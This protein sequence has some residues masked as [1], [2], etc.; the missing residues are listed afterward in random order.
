MAQDQ[1]SSRRSIG[2]DPLTHVVERQRQENDGL[3]AAMRYRAVIEQAKGILM[4][5]TGVGPETAFQQLVGHSQRT[6][7]KVTRVAAAVV[8]RTITSRPAVTS[9]PPSDAQILE[10]ATSDHAAQRLAASA[11]AAA[12]DFTQLIQ[13]VVQHTAEFGVVAGTL[14]L[15][16]PD[17]ALRLVA[18]HGVETHVVSGWQRIPPATDLPMC[19]AAEQRAPVWLRDRHERLERY[20]GSARFPGHREASAALPLLLERQ[21]IGCLSLDWDEPRD[22]DEPM[23]Q[24]LLDVAEL[25]AAPVAMLLRRHDDTLP[26]LELEP[27]YAHWFRAFLDSTPA[28]TVILEPQLEAGELVELRVL[29][30]NR[31]GTA[32]PELVVGRGLLESHPE[33]ASGRFL[34]DARTVMRTGLPQRTRELT[35]PTSAGARPISVE[36]AN[37]V[38]IGSLLTLNWTPPT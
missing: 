7:L 11:V 32:H 8:A 16:E 19:G 31:A 6:Q 18:W 24:H 29:F 22:L 20:P 4:A 2:A 5:R 1:S 37:L 35:L 25:C 13:A 26:D 30:V 28:P 34:D 27:G 9:P 12:P 15:A 23:R 17:G 38:R 33:L 3:R 21:L 10:D 14:A 36:D